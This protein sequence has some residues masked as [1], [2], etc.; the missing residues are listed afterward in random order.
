MTTAHPPPSETSLPWRRAMDQAIVDLLA[1]NATLKA[2][3]AGTDVA[4]HPGTKTK[5]YV[6]AVV[7]LAL[8]GV[9]AILILFVVRPD[10]DN[11]PL[12]TIVLGFIGPFIAIFLAAAVRE[13]QL[14]T[15]S[16]LSQLLRVTALASVAEGRLAA[17]HDAQTGKDAKAPPA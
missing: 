8:T 2:Q 7:A 4:H 5:L 11:T 3:M 14:A 10:Q 1:E 12:I 15:N 6:H 16:R 9:A 13:G 17:E